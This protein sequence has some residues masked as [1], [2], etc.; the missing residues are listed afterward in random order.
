[1]IE[2]AHVVY[3][4]GGKEVWADLQKIRSGR[5]F[6]RLMDYAEDQLDAEELHFATKCGVLVVSAE[7]ACPKLPL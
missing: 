2:F 3:R 4:A 6:D 5:A 1:M 7:S